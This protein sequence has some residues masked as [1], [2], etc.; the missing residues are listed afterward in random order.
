MGPL[1]PCSSAR[2][3]PQGQPTALGLGP[4]QLLSG[5]GEEEALEVQ[6][7]DDVVPH[8]AALVVVATG[9]VGVV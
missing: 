6:A 5:D 3:L 2:T 1:P 7:S 4:E 9:A 8:G